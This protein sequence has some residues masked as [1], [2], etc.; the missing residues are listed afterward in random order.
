MKRLHCKRS[1]HASCVWECISWP[2][3]AWLTHT[4]SWMISMRILQR[5]NQ[6]SRTILTL[7]GVFG[8]FLLQETT[9]ESF[10]FLMGNLWFWWLWERETERF[11]LWWDHRCFN[12]QN[13]NKT[14]NL[15]WLTLTKETRGTLAQSLCWGE[16]YNRGL[17]DQDDAC[18]PKR[19]LLT[20]G[21]LYLLSP[22]LLVH[23]RICFHDH[24]ELLVAMKFGYVLVYWGCFW[25]LVSN[26]LHHLF[27][28]LWIVWFL[29]LHFFYIMWSV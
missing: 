11:L 10:R 1:V 6:I 9:L 8:R 22:I 15:F 14:Q 25:P 21:R 29:P 18:C 23:V 20:S 26:V 4:K 13:Q 28:I 16:R 12:P 3:R 24:L 5:H 7:F 2:R 19:P 27:W 17:Q